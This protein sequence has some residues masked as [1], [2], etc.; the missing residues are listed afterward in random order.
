[1]RKHLIYLVGLA[2]SGKS[3]VGKRL[4]KKMN[5]RFADTDQIVIQRA[6]RSIAQ[7]F[8]N[9]GEADF[10]SRESKVL[11][12][13]KPGQGLVVA[14]GGG[15]PLKAANRSFMKQH[16][17]VVHLRVSPKRIVSRLSQAELRKRP[18]LAK[19]LQAL[20]KMSKERAKH[21]AAAHLSVRATGHPDQIASRIMFKIQAK[22]P[23]VLYDKTAR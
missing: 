19:G 13:L 9:P 11:R 4:A 3:T 2:G 14:T 18:L 16:G 20:K 15:L 21:Y 10:R 22:M 5:W 7:I 6:G 12:S 1:M 8:E 17:L 23:Q